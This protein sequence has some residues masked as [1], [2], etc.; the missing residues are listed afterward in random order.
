MFNSPNNSEI[1]EIK[2]PQQR[3]ISHWFDQHPSSNA[4]DI[5]NLEWSDRVQ[6]WR[7]NASNSSKNPVSKNDLGFG[8]IYISYPVASIYL[9]NLLQAFYEL[10]KAVCGSL[11][12]VSSWEEL[13]PFAYLTSRFMD[14]WRGSL[15]NLKSRILDRSVSGDEFMRCMYDI[16]CAVDKLDSSLAEL[17]E[18]FPVIM[19]DGVLTDEILEDMEAAV[20]WR[21]DMI[22]K[23]L[24]FSE[25]EIELLGKRAKEEQKL[26]ETFTNEQ[27]LARVQHA[28]EHTN[29][30]V[31]SKSPLRDLLRHYGM[32]A[33]DS[34]QLIPA[35]VVYVALFSMLVKFIFGHDG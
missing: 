25:S 23:T 3:E 26:E 18:N 2:S 21:F 11:C 16:R 19:N 10:D 35:F 9:W 6:K 14:E 24:S 33:F 1:I 34:R 22:D 13:P 15:V 8:N 7:R 31:T 32:S 29:D 4:P 27:D 20:D 28:L 12:D 30:H 5:Y 17:K